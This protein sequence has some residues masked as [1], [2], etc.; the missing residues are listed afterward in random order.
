M[1]IVK[2]VI[3]TSILAIGSTS[4]FASPSPDTSSVQ[5]AM[6]EQSHAVKAPVLIET[7]IYAQKASKRRVAKVVIKP[8][9]TLVAREA[10][11]SD[12]S[13][14]IYKRGQHAKTNTKTY[15][16]STPKTKSMPNHFKK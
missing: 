6:T 12:H 16:P 14:F 10:S 15:R 4:A 9:E 2:T 3:V 1:K 8:V 5:P 7:G 11:T 13:P